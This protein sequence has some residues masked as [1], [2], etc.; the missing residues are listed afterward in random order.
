MVPT[1]RVGRP[2]VEPD[3]P[4][5]TPRVKQGNAKGSFPDKQIGH[6]PNG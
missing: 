3:T 6:K 1:I 5:H 2:Q 4:G